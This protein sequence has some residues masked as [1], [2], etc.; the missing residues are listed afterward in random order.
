MLPTFQTITI[1]VHLEGFALSQQCRAGTDRGALE[2]G[3]FFSRL[4]VDLTWESW[5]EDGPS[6]AS[7]PELAF[8]PALCAGVRPLGEIQG[9]Q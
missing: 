9:A 7:H 4:P 8:P 2:T 5:S 3:I 6:L 1:L